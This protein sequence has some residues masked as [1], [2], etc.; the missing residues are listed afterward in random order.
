ML[1]TRQMKSLQVFSLVRANVNSHFDFDC[2]HASRQT[3]K[4][5]P[6]TIITSP[7]TSL[8][9]ARHPLSSEWASQDVLLR[10]S[11]LG[12]DPKDTLARNVGR[13]VI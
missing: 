5:A 2:P 3:R 13:Y 6:S 1:R 9:Q 8:S 10:P 12:S 7:A 11:K 4:S